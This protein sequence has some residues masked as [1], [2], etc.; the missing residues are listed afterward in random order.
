MTI[1]WILQEEGEGE[2]SLRRAG[3]NYTGP[4]TSVAFSPD[5]GNVIDFRGG[6]LYVNGTNIL[7]AIHTETIERKAEDSSIR[8]DLV[9]ETSERKGDFSS[10]RP[11]PGTL[12]ISD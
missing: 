2:V 9:T 3:P 5:M 7:S 4:D 11:G 1:N 10:I 8:S 6:A 12:R